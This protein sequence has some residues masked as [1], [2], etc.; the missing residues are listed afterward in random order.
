MTSHNHSKSSI[1]HVAII[2]D[3]NGRWAGK[4]GRS[5]V[6]GHIRGS[7]NVTNIV[8]DAVQLGLKS[9][10]LYTFS[11]ENWSRPLTEVNTIFKL[12]KK[13]LVGE[14]KRI[15]KN[16]IRFRIIGDISSLSEKT[17]KIITDL[18]SET[19]KS[20]GLNLTLAFGYGGRSEI[21]KSVNKF[22]EKNPCKH[23]SE[24]ELA[25]YLMTPDCGD[26][27]LMIRTGGDRRISN[28]LLW[29]MAYAELF[30]TS[31]MWPDFTSTEF[32]N[33]IESVSQRERR[34]G[35]IGSTENLQKSA[36]QAVLNKRKF[37]EKAGE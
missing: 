11:T 12:L 36:D 5:R 29:Q 22:I 33:I 7:R 35:F 27:D 1:K 14:R 19:K 10:T 4:R 3:G 15:L 8:E 16:H 9:L 20:E 13:F 28:F 31:T 17:R 26:V 32:R 37:V 2:M 24:E 18:E 23:I 6:W 34:F 25:S 30:F 21:V